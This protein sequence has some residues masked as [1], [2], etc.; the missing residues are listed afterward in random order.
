MAS[1]FVVRC[2]YY[3]RDGF[4]GILEAHANLFVRPYSTILDSV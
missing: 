1:L 4:D 3:D 2:G